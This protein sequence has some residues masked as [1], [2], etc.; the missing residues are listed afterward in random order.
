MIVKKWSHYFFDIVEVVKERSKDAETKVGCVIVDKNNRILSTGYNSFPSGCDDSK[1]PDTRPDKYPY[2]VHAEINALLYAKTDLHG[3]SLYCN[4]SPCSDCA[5]AI[6]TAGVTKVYFLEPYTTFQSTM[7]FWEACGYRH[8][9]SEGFHLL[10]KDESNI[11]YTGW[12]FF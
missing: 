12:S 7:P 11:D 9:I 8:I 6:V 4:I 10:T 3:A 5:K 1:L 2:M